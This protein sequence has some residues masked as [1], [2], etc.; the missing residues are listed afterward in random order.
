[1]T[2]VA[3]LICVSKAF[4]QPQA[5]PVRV[6]EQVSLAI[7]PGQTLAIQGPSGSGKSTLLHILSGFEPPDS[8]TVQLA[9]SRLPP[10]EASQALADLRAR[11]IG[12]VFQ[13]HHL[14]G[15]CTALENVQ[16]AALALPAG[17]A[18]EAALARAVELLEAIGLA[19]RRHHRPAELS[20]GQRQRVAVARAMVNRPALILADEPTG[21]L[22]PPTARE[23]CD[24]LLRLAGQ[25]NT[26]LLVVT[27]DAAVADRM[28]TRLRL[29]D[30]RLEPVSP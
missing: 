21:A 19:D 7:G 14:I 26:A 20:G 24:L 13:Q 23:L 6:L 15:A 16:L 17:P 3:E 30:G 22:D 27:H 2:S 12:M 18:R 25:D 9:G 11:H 1:M 28:Q 29:A 8:G 4:F 10:A 5:P